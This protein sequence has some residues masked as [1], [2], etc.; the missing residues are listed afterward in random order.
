MSITVCDKITFL[1]QFVKPEG[2]Q[3]SLPV[4][5]QQGLKEQLK[6]GAV[7]RN[8]RKCRRWHE[9]MKGRKKQKCQSPLCKRSREAEEKGESSVKGQERWMISVKPV[10]HSGQKS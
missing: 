2:R 3:R 1:K 7:K 8:N 9:S 4:R 5:V 10:R 6:I